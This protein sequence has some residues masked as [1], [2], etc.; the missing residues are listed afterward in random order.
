MSRD[1]A[2]TAAALRY[3]VEVAD[4]HAHLWRVTLV[5]DHP[6]PCQRVSLPVWIPGSY[7]VRECK[8]AVIL[9]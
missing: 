3:T 7:L 8:N 6:A 2:R 1:A 5:V 4:A 9:T